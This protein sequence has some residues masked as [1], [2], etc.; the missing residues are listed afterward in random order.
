MNGL[1]QRVVLVSFLAGVSGLGGC[2]SGNTEAGPDGG[3]QIIIYVSIDGDDGKSGI[4]P[5]AAVQTIA[6]GIERALGCAPK[7]C[8]LH[9]AEGTYDGQVE[10]A[11]GVSVLGGYAGDWSVRDPVA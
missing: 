1:F 5:S 7:P 10:L 8:E 9:V 4:S 11:N 6:T 3:D 2:A